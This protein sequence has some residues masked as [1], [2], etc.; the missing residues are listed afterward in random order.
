[1]HAFMAKRRAVKIAI[2]GA[3]IA[4]PTLAYW[5]LRHGHSPTL[6]EAAST[7]RTGGYMIDF[8]GVGYDVANRMGILPAIRAAGYDLQ[9]VRYVDN[10]GRNAGSISAKTM[11]RELG[12]QFTSLSRGDLAALVYRSIE[13]RAETLFG[14]TVAAIQEH[15]RGVRLR[16]DNRAE[17]EFDILVGADGLH[18]KVRALVF[19]PEPEF[20]RR[21]GYYVAAFKAD[22]YRPR[23]ELA[24][25]SYGFP[26]RQISRFA[27]RDDRTMF[28]LVFAAEHLQG[29]EPSSLMERKQALSR[30]FA[31]AGW[32][33]PQIAAA[34]EA[35]PEVY[36]DRVSQIAMTS[37]TKG[38]VTL[39][40]DA[41]A[42][43]SLLAGEGTG[44]GMT[45]AYVLAGEIA[46]ADG[47]Y[48][49]AFAAY[50]S[51]LKRFVEAKQK[52]A[53]DFASAFTPRTALGVWLR[54]QAT[55]LMAVPGMPGLLMGARDP[56]RLQFARLW[57]L[58]NVRRRHFPRH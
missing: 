58:A 42:C 7:L 40:G 9:E 35:A 21:I 30:A 50:E 55:R 1:M 19:G 6:I 48:R 5:L 49:G 8:W 47:D 29:S 4:G 11:A 44:L 46:R 18:S 36:F 33:W 51:R 10:R 15:D 22:H 34:L 37:W 16:L 23:D 32:E 24:Y 57:D 56:G 43:V 26:G 41:A 2:S 25:V 28:L 38:R 20:E 3:G 17:R 54:N 52:A 12:D 13:D 31:N 14:T 39:V 45:E 27:Q 53:R